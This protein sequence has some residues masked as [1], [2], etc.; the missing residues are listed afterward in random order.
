[1]AKGNETI[2]SSTTSD[3]MEPIGGAF[4]ELFKIDGKTKCANQGCD[5][6]ADRIVLMGRAEV[7]SLC[8]AC[9]AAAD[10]DREEQE[11]ADEVKRLFAL[12]GRTAKLAR[13]GFDTYPKDKAGLAAAEQARVWIDRYLGRSEEQMCPDLLLIGN[14]GTGK[15][16]LAWSIVRHLI[17]EHRIAARLVNWRVLLADMQEAMKRP[18]LAVQEALGL[19]RVPVLVLDDVGSE[20]P[21][22]WRRD[23]LATLIE[24]RYQ[25]ELPTIYTSNYT[26]AELGERLGHDDVR[27]GQRIVSRMMEDAMIVKF[28]GEDR[29]AH[30]AAV[31]AA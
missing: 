30:A 10:A 3:G 26:L 21:T 17:E 5:G 2:S 19:H 1:M 6:E 23:E 22:D 28:D 11:R 24:R 9:Q 15:T 13:M 8:P 25:A 16:G 20:R 14:V 12:S 4:S 31:A 29:R 7:P 27:V 18:D